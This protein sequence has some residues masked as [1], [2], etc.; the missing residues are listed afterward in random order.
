M[1]DKF[2]L[3]M[4]AVD[5]N[6]LEEAMTTGK[7]KRKPLPWMGIAV[8]ASLVIIIGLSL[9]PSRTAPLTASELSEMGYDMKLPADAKHISYQLVTLSDHQGAQANFKLGNTNYVYQTVK[10]EERMQLLDKPGTQNQV[11]SWNAGNLNIQLLSSAA[12]TSVSWY[13]P[14]EQTQCYLTAYA[15]TQ[16]V[17]TTA[18]QI[19][20]S[21]GLDVTV[22]PQH[23]TNVTYNAFLLHDLTVAET[24]FQIDGIT[25]SYRMAGTTELIEDFRDISGLEKTF[26]EIVAGEVFWCRAKINFD[27]NGQGKILWFDLVPGILYSLSMDSGA[28]KDTLMDMANQL[29]EP[30][31]ENN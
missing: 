17:L 21:M 10:S 27:E 7:R 11:L 18:S 8:A 26:E 25:Y 16:K 20:E 22:A 23:A 4:N 24:T 15:D 1:K 31:Q 13:L 19:L 29:F 2:Q 9:I 3:W 14:E 6:L 28:S 12:E 5:D 30:A